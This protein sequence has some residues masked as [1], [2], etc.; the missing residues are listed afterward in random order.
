MNKGKT[1]PLTTRRTK[2]LTIGEYLALSDTDMG[3]HAGERADEL[4]EVQKGLRDAVKE[5]AE[6]WD[7]KKL[8]GEPKKFQK[9]L[10]WTP[11][12]PKKIKRT[13]RLP[14]DERHYS[15]AELADAWG[16]SA[17]TIRSL[18]EGEPDVIIY[19]DAQG[20]NRKRRYRT[21]KIP[22][23]VAMRLKNRLTARPAR[24]PRGSR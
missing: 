13:D 15:P 24:I 8:L 22:A 19:G 3:E 11:V 9:F 2:P 18:F 23:S 4:A 6:L 10:N 21:I 16:L 5:V 20:T 14:A 7:G 12:K 1:K 17:D